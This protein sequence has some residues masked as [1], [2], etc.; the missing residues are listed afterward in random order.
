MSAAKSNIE[1]LPRGVQVA[2]AL[3]LVALVAFPFVGSDFYAQMVARMMIMAIFAM[4]L[5]LLQGVTGLG[6][7]GPCGVLWHCRLCAG[8]HDAR[9]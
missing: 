9:R 3:G 1:V 5:D 6:V 2:L 7:A 8:L 4:S